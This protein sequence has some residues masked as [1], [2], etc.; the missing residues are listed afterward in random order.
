MLHEAQ[1]VAVHHRIVLFVLQQHPHHGGLG[2]DGI[3]ALCDALVLRQVQQVRMKTRAVVGPDG[4]N[5]SLH[6]LRAEYAGIY[7]QITA[8]GVSSQP[9]LFSGE[10][11]C[12]IP[13]IIQRLLL[14]G[15]LRH[16]G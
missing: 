14:G 7:C 13:D 6:A 10:L 16:A 9:Q 11:P 15:H 2:Y 1:L 4:N 12:H 3:N 5:A 8:L